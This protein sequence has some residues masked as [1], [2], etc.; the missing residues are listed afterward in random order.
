M[1]ITLSIFSSPSSF[2]N[3]PS[4]WLE[5][6]ILFASAGYK[7]SDNKVDFPEPETPVM[8][9]KMPSGIST[10]IFFK[11]CSLTPFNFKNVPFPLRRFLGIVMLIAPDR[12][13]PVRLSLTFII[14][15]GVPWATTFPP[16]TPAPGPKS[17]MWSAVRSVCSSCSTTIKVLPR[18]RR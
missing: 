16:W 3:M 12:Y 7:T 14:C 18:L 6:L 4:I 8:Q 13:C 1:S 2:L 17:T 9:V 15:S 10:L 5:P 11:L